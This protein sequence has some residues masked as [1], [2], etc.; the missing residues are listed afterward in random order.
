M[1]KNN[2]KETAYNRPFIK[3]RADPQIY[4]SESGM[5]YFT[6]SVPEYDRIILRQSAS[7]SG[8]PFAKERTLW[9]KHETGPQSIHIWAPE[10]HQLWGKWYIYYAAGDKADIWNIRPYV[11]EC[12]GNDPFTDEWRE[13]G[14]MQPAKSDEFSFRA[15]SLDATIIEYEQ[16]YYYIW[17]EKTGVGKMISNL[18]I[19]KMES[20]CRLAT[21]Q[22]LLSTPDYLWERHGFW[23][24]EGPAVLRGN[25]QLFL[26]YS[27]SDTSQFYCMGMLS[28]K[29]GADLL[30]PQNWKKQKTPVL[31][32]SEAYGIFGPGHNSFVKSDDN[33]S[34]LCVFHGRMYDEI[35][36]DPL[37]DP[38]R[39]TM[40]L[41]VIWDSSGMPIFDF[42]NICTLDS[43]TNE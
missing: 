13:L 11:L 33:S 3:N 10:L 32:T 30:D 25:G 8:L 22:V 42:K 34:D 39:H 19:A 36:G 43:Q 37:Y 24:N 20:P 17:A 41:K 29:E 5:Y 1:N 14:S 21:D 9:Q 23:V 38:N 15:F 28:I 16:D 18:Y 7:L 31:K 12:M 4:R 35:I 27:A 2:Y 26:T 40:I 6:G